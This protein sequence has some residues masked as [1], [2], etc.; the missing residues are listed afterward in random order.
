MLRWLIA[1]L[2][3]FV[4]AACSGDDSDSEQSRELPRGSQ[5]VEL[6]PAEFTTE[7]DNPYWPMKPGSRW[8]FRER[9]ADGSV[10]RVEVTVT[11]LKKLVDGIEAVVVHDV[12]TQDGE[13][14]EDTFDWYAQDAEGNV[15]YLGED[16]KEFENGKVTST[17]GSWE[18]GVDGAQAGVVVPAE[19][20]VGMTYRQE[21]YKGEAEDSAEVLSLDA[22]T[23]VPAGSFD[24]LLQT[25]DYTP[26]EP[27]L[28]EHKYY[29]RGLGPVLAVAVSG[30][31]SREELLSFDRG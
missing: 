2:F 9:D 8:V 17:E 7:I 3:V 21:Y 16:T 20:R 12:V 15:W 6:D 30:G 1:V 18:A 24:G 5:T 29:E 4:A 26:L 22:E 19:P 25:K 23:V 14:F 31:G 11:S 13:V 28:V 10:T 27:G